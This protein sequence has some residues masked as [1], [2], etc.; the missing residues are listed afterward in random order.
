[1]LLTERLH[2]LRMPFRALA[3]K[4]RRFGL[5]IPLP[6]VLNGSSTLSALRQQRGQRPTKAQAR[7]PSPS[8]QRCCWFSAI[9]TVSS[10]QAMTHP[11]Y[12]P[13][14]DSLHLS[15]Y[16]QFFAS[17]VTLEAV[18]QTGFPQRIKTP[19]TQEECDEL[20]ERFI[21]LRGGLYTGGTDCKQY[22]ELVFCRERPCRLM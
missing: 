2:Y 19:L 10:A 13:L 22:V 7:L 4:A 3:V 17:P 21:R 9:S 20:C 15:Q 8:S 16:S 6:L 12:R 14:L 5:R 11:C 1:M 18:K